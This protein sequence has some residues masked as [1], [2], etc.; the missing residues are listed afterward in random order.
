MFSGKMKK[1]NKQMNIYIYFLNRFDVIK[2]Y[3]LGSKCVY[4]NKQIMRTK[5]A[6]KYK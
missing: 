4:K 6:C 5:H 2:I 1:K 3:F